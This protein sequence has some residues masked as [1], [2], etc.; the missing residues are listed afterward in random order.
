MVVTKNG[1]EYKYDFSSPAFRTAFGFLKGE[2]LESLPVGWTDL[3]NGVR[4]SVQ[5]YTTFDWNENKFEA[6]D[7]YF[8]IQYVVKGCEICWVCDRS[9]L[10]VEIPYS[11]DGDIVFFAEPE[12]YSSVYLGEGDFII[13]APEDAHKPRCK[14]DEKTAV[15]KIVIKVPV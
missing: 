13:L 7:R 14:V 4:V 3:D 9:G 6:H 10:S 1:L 5:E 12:H 8:D 11:S 15:K 2:N